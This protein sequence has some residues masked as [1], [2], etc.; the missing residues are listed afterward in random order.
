MTALTWPSKMTG[1]TTMLQR[2]GV[3]QAGADRM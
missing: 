2:R 3:A 1:R